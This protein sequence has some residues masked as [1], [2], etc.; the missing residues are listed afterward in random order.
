MSAV[1]VRQRAPNITGTVMNVLILNNSWSPVRVCS[2][3]RAIDK[4][5]R[6]K[7]V[8]LEID[9]DGNYLQFDWNGWVE[10]SR[11]NTAPMNERINGV[12]FFINRPF[13]II[14]TGKQRFEHKIPVPSRK[15]IFL[16]DNFICQFCGKTFER[17]HLTI[18][19]I[20]PKSRGGKITWENS[21]TCCQKCN[22]KKGNR[23]P[24]EANM[25]LINKPRIP[26]LATIFK[27]AIG[28]NRRW[29][30]FLSS[31]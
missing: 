15:N 17:S 9:K 20:M 3:F 25:H 22:S 8:V 26:S 30:E 11:T 18:D 5:Y 2:V 21:A 16:R 1:R 4:V 23:T 14:L 6:G 12:R 10:Y 13:V 27:N 7:A 24:E 28:D 31:Y 29:N 19:H